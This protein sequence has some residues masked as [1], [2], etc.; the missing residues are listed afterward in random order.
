MDHGT[1]DKTIIPSQ[2]VHIM[3]DK[4]ILSTR[5]CN[6]DSKTSDGR[7]LWKVPWHNKIILG[8]TDTPS[9]TRISSFKPT[10]QEINFILETARGY[11]ILHQQEK[12]ILSVFCRFKTLAATKEGAKTKE[13]SRIQSNHF[14]IWIGK[15]YWWKWTTYH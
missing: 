1:D 14:R 8:T 10:E 6:H 11:I 9:K 15:Y 3:I 4:K 5:F 12:D 13:L 7:V 2:G